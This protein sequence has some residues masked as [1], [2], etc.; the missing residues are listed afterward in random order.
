MSLW[1]KSYQMILAGGK[2]KNYFGRSGGKIILAGVK[3]I[4]AGG[5]I[6]LAG[7]NYWIIECD[8][9]ILPDWSPP[10]NPIQY[11]RANSWI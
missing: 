1:Q 8:E 3:I 10:D 4:L 11:E 7:A 5:E 9:F 6:I 2:I